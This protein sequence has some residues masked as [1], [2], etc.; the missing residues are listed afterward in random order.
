M[1]STKIS[2]QPILTHAADAFIFF[3]KEDAELS[4]ARVAEAEA[5]VEKLNRE[6]SDLAG[7]VD[8][9][10]EQL[11]TLG[12]QKKNAE[13][14]LSEITKEVEEQTKNSSDLKKRHLHV[15]Q[16]EEYIRDKYEVIGESYP[17]F[18]I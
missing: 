17:E 8:S 6:E 3:I 12:S 13:K 14:E 18:K 11:V 2:D 4:L 16:K 15:V 1:V 7:S 5:K 10:N 9:L